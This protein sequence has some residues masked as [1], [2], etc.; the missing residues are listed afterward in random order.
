MVTAL[1]AQAPLLEVFRLLGRSAKLP[2]S[3]LGF[4][5]LQLTTLHMP[6]GTVLGD[7]CCSPHYVLCPAPHVAEF[8][9]VYNKTDEQLSGWI[10]E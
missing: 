1:L 9:N 4:R 3:V 2:L 5:C 7:L 10:V 8:E 6:E